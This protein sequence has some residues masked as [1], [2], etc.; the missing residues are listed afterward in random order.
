MTVTRTMITTV[1]WLV[2]GRPK[3][4]WSPLLSCRPLSPREVAAPKSVAMIASASTTRPSGFWWAFSPSSGVNVALTSVGA[5]LRNEKY[6]MAPP[7]TAYSAHPL[8]PQWK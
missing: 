5:P 4:Y 1:T 8:K 2:L 3:R 7:M 6:A